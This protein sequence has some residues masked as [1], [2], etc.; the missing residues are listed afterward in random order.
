MEYNEFVNHVR[1]GMVKIL[2]EGR[3]VSIHKVI[4]NNDIELDAI[5]VNTKDSNI[6]PTIYIN[7]YYSEYNSGKAIDS[8]VS[9]ICS[10][11][12][13][14]KDKME[15]NVDDF[16]DFNKVKDRIV[17]KLINKASN[18]KLLSTIPSIEYLDLAI[19]F[20]YL[21]DNDYLG[22]ATALIQNTHI[23]VW[24]ISVNELYEVAIIN[25][26]NLL[27]EDLRSMHD[28]MKEMLVIDLEKKLMN[29]KEEVVNDTEKSFEDIAEEMLNDI[30]PDNQLEMFVLTNKQKLHGAS[31]ILYNNVLEEFS[32]NYNSDLFILPSSIHEVI[33]VPAT[34]NISKRE[35][36]QMV[37]SVNTEEV[38][39]GEVL[40]DHVYI[41]SKKEKLLTY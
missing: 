19:V 5:T 3:L 31:C 21:I 1:E 30:K 4:K 38:D 40:A 23:D 34:K 29:S 7:Q 35:L 10:L 33:I 11:Y 36:T 14:N 18:E 15:F 41:Y 12:E 6:S 9:E 13:E 22:S 25:T 32:S 8:I 26:P 24:E 37:R 17:Y 39:D 27:K 2:G 16:M 28:I 20:Y